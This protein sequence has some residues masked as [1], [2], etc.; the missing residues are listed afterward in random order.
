[1]SIHVSRALLRVLPGAVA[2][3]ALLVSATAGATQKRM[4]LMVNLP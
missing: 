4:S 1:M 3:A 2:A